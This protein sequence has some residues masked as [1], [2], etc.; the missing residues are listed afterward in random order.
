MQNRGRLTTMRIWG[1]DQLPAAYRAHISKLPRR[2]GR[3][4][5]ATFTLAVACMSG[6]ASI[7]LSTYYLGNFP[8]FTVVLPWEFP[9]WAQFPFFATGILLFGTVLLDPSVFWPVLVGTSIFAS[10]PL[11]LRFSI[12]DEWLVGCLVLGAFAAVVV[13]SVPRRKPPLHRGW[14]S[15]FLGFG[16][17]LF[18]MS[19]VGFLAYA[20]PKALRFSALFLVIVILGYL[21]ARYDFPVPQPE[22]ITLLVATVGLVYFTLY[23]VHGVVFYSHVVVTAMWEGMGYAGAAGQTAPGIAAVPAALI[24]IA[25]ERGRRK[26]LGWAVLILAL[27]VSCLADTRAGM[28]IILISMLMVLLAIG[29]KFFLKIAVVGMVTSVL[30]GASFLDR[31]WMGLEMITDTF[32]AS[33][34]ESGVRPVYYYGAGRIVPVAKGDAGRFLYARGAVEALRQNPY[35]ALTGAGIYGYFPFAGPYYQQVAREYGVPTYDINLAVALGRTVE[36]PRPPT[37]G[38]LIAETG[39]IGITL[40]AVCCMALIRAT[41]FRTSQLYRLK[42][43]RRPNLPIVAPLVLA[44]A[45]SYFASDALD[46]MQLYVIL[47]PF[48]LVHAWGRIDKEA[49]SANGERSPGAR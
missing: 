22:R 1:T 45:W 38:V 3:R 34:I 5:A 23:V 27:L 24:L 36:P 15:L 41:V 39:L 49:R 11:V 33:R 13:G 32:A 12:L 9:L 43:L 28:V 42:F 30:I 4:R 37:L 2:K 48:G 25:R 18:I 8:I 10:G 17:Y 19:V 14:V 21:L 47:M 44:V 29:F 35:Y 26:A 40:L 20:N 7:F 16:T 31:P 6:I 46:M